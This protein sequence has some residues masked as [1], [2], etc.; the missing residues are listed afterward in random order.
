MKLDKDGGFIG[1]EALVEAAERGPRTRLCCLVLD[2]PRS[3]APR[4]EPVRI[5]GEIVG[6]VT[7]GG[8]GYTVERSIAYAYL[9]PEHAEHG[10]SVAV[11]IFGDWVSGEV[12]REPLFD[13]EGAGPGRRGARLARQ[14]APQRPRMVGPGRS[15]GGGRTA[16]P[17]SALERVQLGREREEDL[18]VGQD[19][20]GSVVGAVYREAELARQAGEA[21]RLSAPSPRGGV[22]LEGE[23]VR[24]DHQKGQAGGEHGPAHEALLERGHVGDHRSAGERAESSPSTS[25]SAG[26]PTRSSCAGRGCGSPPAPASGG[27]DE[28]AGRP[29]PPRPPSMGIVANATISSSGRSRPVVSRSS[30]HRP[31]SRHGV[32][33]SGMGVCR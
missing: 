1:R 25:L 19:V 13:P 33:G 2:D 11:E 4:N 28:A 6:R 29:D 21:D 8:F 20:T 12:A 7:T 15:G 24:V 10:T 32:A 27:A 22:D 26:A 3:V 23:G 16:S 31:A 17:R 5:E 30:T 18:A 9:P 14:D